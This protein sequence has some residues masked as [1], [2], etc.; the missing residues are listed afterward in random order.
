MT[1]MKEKAVK[2]LAQ[3]SSE[4]EELAR[5]ITHEQRLK[6]FMTTK[7]NER[8]GLDDSLG[9]RH[10]QSSR[11]IGALSKHKVKVLKFHVAYSRAESMRG[12]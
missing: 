5:L 10:G 1:T 4:V 8:T 2:D 9:H 12:F 3:Y 11:S 6:H 7:C